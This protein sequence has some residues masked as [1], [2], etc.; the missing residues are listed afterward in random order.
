M[1]KEE[2]EEMVRRKGWEWVMMGRVEHGQGGCAEGIA[3]EVVVGM[4]GQA[5]LRT[6]CEAST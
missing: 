6:I 2:V 1:G 3:A 5:V 4:S